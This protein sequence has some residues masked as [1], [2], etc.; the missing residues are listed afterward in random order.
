M[1]GKREE[2]KKVLK[3]KILIA[4]KEVFLEN[5]YEQATME[6]IATRAEVGL[7]TAYN[8][9]TSKDELFLLIMSDQI[10]AINDNAFVV[11]QDFDKH[12]EDLVFDYI[13]ELLIKI[14]VFSKKVWREVISVYFSS[15]KSNN[16]M[17]ERIIKVEYDFMDGIKR[18]LESLQE[19]KLLES[20][21][22]VEEAVELIYSAVTFQL[23]GYMFSDEME[24]SQ[25]T[26]KLKSQI[27][28]ILVHH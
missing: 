10:F 3:E 27:K 25:I 14:D 6:Q 9:F 8:Y 5:G 21:F 28:F 20:D 1:A 15:M 16:Q 2:K 24:F 19:K 18:L 11:N 13:I 12:I 23:M 22:K 4:S 17:I 26:T 7:G